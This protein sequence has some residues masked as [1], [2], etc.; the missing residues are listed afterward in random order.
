MGTVDYKII[1]NFLDKD[2]FLE[3]KN[4]VFYSSIPWFWKKNQTKE[5]AGIFGHKIYQ[6]HLPNSDLYIK[7]IHS[8]ILKLKATALMDVKLNL[9]INNNKQESSNWHTDNGT[10][11]SKTA[12]LYLNTCN[13]YTVLKLY[14]KELNVMCEENKMLIFNSNTLHR[15]VRQ[16]DTER[17]IILN[18]NYYDN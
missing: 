10:H 5:D 8:I 18:I 2:I 9:L 12:I 1:D 16:T 11:N 4:Y 14:D 3:L 17:R 15:A 7:F 13:G 6:N